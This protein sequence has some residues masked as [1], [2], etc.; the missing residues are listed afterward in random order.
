[1]SRS[2]SRI[3]IAVAA[4]ALWLASPAAYAACS[5]WSDAPDL[6]HLRCGGSVI[7]SQQ[8]ATNFADSG[9]YG[10]ASAFCQSKGAS[11]CAIVNYFTPDGYASPSGAVVYAT[12]GAMNAM[13]V[14]QIYTWNGQ[15]YSNHMASSCTTLAPVNGVCGATPVQC[16][17]GTVS[18]DNGL[19]ICGS[20]RNWTCLGSNGGSNA[21]CSF[22]N[23]PCAGVDGVCGGSP[24]TCA[25]GTPYDD[26][27]RLEC[28]VTRT[29]MCS[30][31]GG[32]SDA[33]CTQP[34]PPCA[35]NGACHPVIGGACS[36]GDVAG[37]NGLSSCGMVRTWSCNGT[38][39]GTNA[40]CSKTN[41]ICVVNGTCGAANGVGRTS[42]PSSSL[43]AFGTASPVAGSGP[44][45]WSCAGSGGGGTASC[46][47]PLRINGQCGSAHG[48]ASPT[49][50]TADL[51]ASGSASPVAGTGP[52]SWTCTGA[53]GGTTASCSA[54]KRV[55]GVC[56]TA[57]GSA[58]ASVPSTGLCSSGS[59]T[60]VT[61]AA[62]S[63][64]W[65]C[66]GV[67][68]G[69][70][71]VCSA[72]QIVHGSCGAAH[73]SNRYIKPSSGL[74]AA[75]AASTVSGTGPFQWTCQGLNGGNSAACM[76]NL[77]VDGECG[78]AH[79][80][81]SLN[82]PAT[83]LCSAGAAGAVTGTGPFAWTCNGLNG[84]IPK[85]CVSLAIVNGRCGSAHGNPA[86][87]TPVSGLCAEGLP[88]PV[89]GA[90]PWVWSCA[91]L[92]GGT[93]QS[94]TAPSPAPPPS[95]GGACPGPT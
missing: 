29:W 26:N 32:G 62:S 84:G 48:S 77:T 21:S 23:P 33:Y 8:L 14:A 31:S 63:W 39:G 47:A 51:C 28:G 91:G 78:P 95:F 7:A 24:L 55:D 74:C 80:G 12:N 59:P 18:S 57:N 93:N 56:G 73:L 60:G 87:S 90:G 52:W 37:D 66:N 88:G 81:A 19:T 4:L 64:N 9:N 75:G 35:V 65:S 86:A 54:L 53:A 34:N 61:S 2:L 45:T 79:G 72:P 69:A 17:S 58:S 70:N 76:A 25:V 36:A 44:W 46:S 50:P 94:C 13:P 10:E 83:S 43:C 41:P 38:N 67:N 5:G 16:M 85:P 15:Y 40:N 82:A 6:S 11:C 68:G 30:A 22:S 92:N 3:P 20:T 1:M 42:A 27:G 89:T 49:P 71:A